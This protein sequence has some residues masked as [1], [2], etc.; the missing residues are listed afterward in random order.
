MP[1]MPIGCSR[2]AL[3]IHMR[4]ALA[5]A[6]FTL[7]SV[8]VANSEQIKHA[9]P[10]PEVQPSASPEFRSTHGPVRLRLNSVEVHRGKLF[11]DTLYCATHTK[12]GISAPYT[13]RWYLDA[14]AE[15]DEQRIVLEA[16][17]ITEVKASDSTGLDLSP[18]PDE[19]GDQ[20]L[21]QS[22]NSQ[23]GPARFFRAA[24]GEIRAV[25]IECLPPSPAA[26]TASISVTVDVQTASRLDVIP[27]APVEEWTALLDPNREFQAEFR[28]TREGLITTVEM[29][30][31]G[32]FEWLGSVQ[33]VGSGVTTVVRDENPE[34]DVYSW[35]FYAPRPEEA[36]IQCLVLRG[37]SH[38]VVAVD[39][40]DV[41]LP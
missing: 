24:A 6:A 38:D 7:S 13:M 40:K 4:S 36:K 30:S 11:G 20:R 26:R 34:G 39:L 28:T 19:A 32:G 33:M 27:I 18:T 15:S 17:A 25:S 21:F 9:A 5:C 23:V 31:A 10:Q 16:H 12:S 2:R 8:C 29:K 22:Q 35:S 3:P 41:P 1:V 14:A 37:V